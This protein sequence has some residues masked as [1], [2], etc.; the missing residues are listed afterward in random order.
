MKITFKSIILTD[1]DQLHHDGLNVT[2][3]WKKQVR[4]SLRA[5][6]TSSDDRGNAYNVVTFRVDRQH[7][8]KRDAEDYYLTHAQSVSGVGTLLITTGQTGDDSVHSLD[9][10]TCTCVGVSNKGQRTVFNYT[11]ECSDFFLG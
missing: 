8:S 5:T 11:I 6:N 9:G 7:A 3:A 1:D 2:R 4:E 10:S